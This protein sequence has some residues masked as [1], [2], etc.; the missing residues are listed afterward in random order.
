MTDHIDHIIAHVGHFD[1]SDS[2]SPMRAAL[3]P[4][5]RDYIERLLFHSFAGRL[6]SAQLSGERPIGS[7]HHNL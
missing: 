5:V 3:A 1:P 7:H 6:S 2:S 4:E